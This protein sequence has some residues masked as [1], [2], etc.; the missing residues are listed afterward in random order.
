MSS[1]HIIGDALK[2]ACTLLCQNV[3]SSPLTDARTVLRLRSFVHSPAIRSALRHGS[4]A[5]PVFALREVARVLSDYSLTYGETI[6]RIRNVLDD[7]HLSAALGLRNPRSISGPDAMR[8][9]E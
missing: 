1:D 8:R 7:P 4:D 5:L 9:W 3:S 2:L 6:V